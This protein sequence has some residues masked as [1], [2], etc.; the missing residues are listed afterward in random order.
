M[1]VE[2]IRDV[3][4]GLLWKVEMNLIYFSVLTEDDTRCFWFHT[5]FLS[6]SKLIF[7]VIY[8][9][10]TCWRSN[11]SLI[12]SILT[13]AI[14]ACTAFAMFCISLA[15]FKVMT[16]I[17]NLFIYIA[18]FILLARMKMCFEAR[19]KSEWV[20]KLNKVR[21]CLCY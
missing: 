18:P 16:K 1:W 8:F 5:F 7:H 2:W 13:I 14:C 4:K 6:N 20:L 12:S 10:R 21:W 19:I 17:I 11:T 3:T 9:S 15:R